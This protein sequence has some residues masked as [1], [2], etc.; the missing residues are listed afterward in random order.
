MTS[1]PRDHTDSIFAQYF[2]VKYN[3]SLTEDESALSKV[4]NTVTSF[5]SLTPF[6][7]KDS[8]WNLDN[9]PLVSYNDTSLKPVFMCKNP[10]TY[11]KEGQGKYN[12]TDYLILCHLKKDGEVDE[13]TEVSETKLEESVTKTGF[14][15]IFP[16]DYLE[17]NK[18]I[19]ELYLNIKYTGIPLDSM[20]YESK[21]NKV[22]LT[23]SSTKSKND[24]YFYRD[25]VLYLIENLDQTIE[26]TS[27]FF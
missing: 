14:N 4:S 6:P 26:F 27:E 21:N 3:N 19:R 7:S 23:F 10:L 25:I 11:S 20:N 2:C 1:F 12:G 16:K 22:S 17:F 15:I 18:T 13:T 9:L 24:I 8:H 5:R